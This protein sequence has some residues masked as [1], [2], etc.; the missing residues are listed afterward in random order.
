MSTQKRQKSSGALWWSEGD[1]GTEEMK[2]AIG[3]SVE[4]SLKCHY[5]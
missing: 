1:L 3:P 2:V 5:G 4:L